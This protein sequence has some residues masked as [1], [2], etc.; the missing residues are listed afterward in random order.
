MANKF[1][2]TCLVAFAVL[3][4]TTVLASCD[5]ITAKIPDSDYYS[6]ILNLEGIT[7]NQLKRIYDA[8]ITEGDTN[9]EKVLNNILL[10]LAE[11]KLGYFYDYKD[12]SGATQ[13][14]LM[15][16]AADSAKM[17]TFLTNHTGYTADASVTKEE[18]VK[19]FYNALL[20]RIEE[21]FYNTASNSTY[22]LRSVFHEKYFYDA[23][24]AELYALGD[25]ASF[26]EVQVDGADTYLDVEKYFGSDYL[27][28]YQDYIARAILPDAMRRL[29]IEEYLYTNNYGTLGRSYARK[30]QYIALADNTSYPTATN[31]L[32]I[33][34]AKN[35]LNASESLATTYNLTL[36]GDLYKGYFDWANMDAAKKTLVDQIYSDAGFTHFTEAG[37]TNDYKETTYGGYITSYLKITNDRWSNDSSTEKDFTS[38]GT[39]D[40]ATGMA[41][42][43]QA[44]IATDKTTEGWYTSSGLSALPSDLKT[45]LFKITV[46][47]E[48][49][50]SGETYGK[51]IQKHYYLT[52]SVYQSEDAYP[53]LIYDKSSTTWY[54]I[55][56]DEA[57][58]YSKLVA[59]TTSPSP[60][61]ASKI[62]EVAHE[63]A[64]LL[65][66]TDTNKKTANQYYVEAMAIAY[67]D[68]SVYDYFKKTFPDLF[69]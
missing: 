51:Y 4:S 50:G 27:T 64:Y 24:K 37:Y 34:Y 62:Y 52:P 69:D 32:M 46:A 7:N 30:V 59:S 31:K 16:A 49:D 15:S 39:Y 40:V 25:R 9:S 26:K 18:K 21:N 67:N 33:A 35:V 6:K 11:S 56:V 12:A 48:V 3:A 43:K 66:D 2:R 54:V 19:Y 29:L 60:Y 68:Q 5:T 8:V 13:P 1:K 22:Q 38:S 58:K 65:S 44:L 55:R 63:V 45:R 14:G 36:L 42:K 23:Q 20:Q 57:V 41:I 28:V 47:N 53:Y 61:S 10:G 17:A